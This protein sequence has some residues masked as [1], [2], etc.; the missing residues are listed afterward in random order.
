M[1]IR[2][3]VVN[4]SLTCTDAGSRRSATVMS[5]EVHPQFVVVGGV[6]GFDTPG[7]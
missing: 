7:R 1:V 6:S 4:R 3:R 2:D 5:T